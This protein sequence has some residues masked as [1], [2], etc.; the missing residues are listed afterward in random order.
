MVSR[1]VCKK[2][3]LF[4]GT[5]VVQQRFLNLHEYQS[6]EIFRKFGVTV[7]K[8]Q[9]AKSLEDV[10]TG[11]TK[12][13]GDI[14]LKSQI[15]AGGRGLGTFV[16]NGFKGGVHVCSSKKQV[17]EFAEKMLGNTLQTK[18]NALKVNTLL[19]MEKFEITKEK[20]FAILMDRASGG[21]VLIGSKIGGTSIEDIAHENP[22][23]IVRVSVDIMEG[24]SKDQA[25]E[26][27]KKMDF[28]GEQ[29]QKAAESILGLYRVFIECD[30]TMVEINPMSVLSDGR[31]IVCDAKVNFDDNAQ[32]RQ[33][34]IHA[35]R[36]TSQEDP[37]ELEASLHDLNYIG[38]DGNVGCMVNGAGL[39]M[40]TMDLLKLYGAE[41]ANFLDVGGAANANQIKAAF[42]ILQNDQKVKSIFVN[43]F[44]G[45]MRC[46][47]IA[48][49]VVQAAKELGLKKPVIV[50]LEGTNVEQGAK[51]LQ[52]S[53][54]AVHFHSDFTEAAKKA[55]ELSK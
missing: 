43:I 2:A 39:A 41:P 52:D 3:S 36:D 38:L 7:P 40:S 20:Y 18:Q 5:S 34:E 26:M 55:V 31:V 10:D 11:I 22:S 15:L 45:I 16:E 51:I 44:G 25:I 13:E 23:S 4:R 12:F 19:L 27:A 32:F 9:V 49:G 6:L 50:R 21:P 37:R 28:V 47:V 29:I 17:K 35:L 54:L 48:T 53:G 42:S 24:L 46:D 14:V 33:Q 1:V 8:F 30:C